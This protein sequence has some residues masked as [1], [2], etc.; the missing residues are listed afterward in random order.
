MHKITASFFTFSCGQYIEAYS[1]STD[2][3]NIWGQHSA[4]LGAVNE[5]KMDCLKT[6]EILATK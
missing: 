5:L 6:I 1:A 3:V 2:R 4:E